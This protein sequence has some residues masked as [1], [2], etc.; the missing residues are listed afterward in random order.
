LSNPNHSRKLLVHHPHWCRPYA[1]ELMT[2]A[3]E[4][5]ARAQCWAT[6]GWAESRVWNFSDSSFNSKQHHI[7]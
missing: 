5:L 3:S 1:D 4:V 2:A 6:A 7:S